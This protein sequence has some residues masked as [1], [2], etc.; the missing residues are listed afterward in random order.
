MTNTI[1]HPEGRGISLKGKRLDQHVRKVG[2]RES[3]VNRFPKRAGGI[4][5]TGAGA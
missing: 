2:K 1:E 4:G 3:K 5:E